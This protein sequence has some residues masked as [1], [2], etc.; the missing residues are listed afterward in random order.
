MNLEVPVMHCGASGDA[1]ALSSQVGALENIF[2]WVVRL[3]DRV[4]SVQRAGLV[5]GALGLGL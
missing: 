5:E 3:N 1:S 2:V 4:E